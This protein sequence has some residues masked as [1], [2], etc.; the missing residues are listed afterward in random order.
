[1]SCLAFSGVCPSSDD[2]KRTHP[3]V[4]DA[5]GF[6]VCYNGIIILLPFS[7]VNVYI[8]SF[9]SLYASIGRVWSFNPKSDTE[10]LNQDRF[11][12]SVSL[13]RWCQDNKGGGG[14]GA[15]W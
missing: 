6:F 8:Q 14:E 11:T 7:F 10:S 13:D 15:K 4:D 5:Y 3:P 9:T 2:M 12:S 1:M